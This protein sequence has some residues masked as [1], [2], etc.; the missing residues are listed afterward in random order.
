MHEFMDQDHTV[1]A[2]ER[3]IKTLM[4]EVEEPDTDPHDEALLGRI[5]L[6]EEVAEVEMDGFALADAKCSQEGSSVTAS[7]R[8]VLSRRESSLAGAA[9]QDG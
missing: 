6:G 5:L 1:A 3:F 2:A 4:V 9:Q 7:R 8:A